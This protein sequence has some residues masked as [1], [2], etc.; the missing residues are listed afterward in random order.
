MATGTIIVIMQLFSGFR[1]TLITAFCAL[2]T[3]IE[4]M[5]AIWMFNVLMGGYAIEMNAVLV[6]NLVTSLGLAFEFCSHIAMNFAGQEGT[7]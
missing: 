7:R 5:G 1:L 4:L 2:L 3:F 6:V